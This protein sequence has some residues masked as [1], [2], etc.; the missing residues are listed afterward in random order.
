MKFLKSIA[1]LALSSAL[2]IG[3][4]DASSKTAEEKGKKEIVAAVK[5]ETASFKIEGMTCAM[6]CAKTIEEKLADMDGVQNAKVDFETKMA[7]VNFDLDKLKSEDLVKAAESCAD[8]K[9]YK[10]SEV[11]LGNKA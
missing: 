5:P 11:K 8:G 9:T 2:F 1:I 7:T 6:G 10:V 4:K 3:C